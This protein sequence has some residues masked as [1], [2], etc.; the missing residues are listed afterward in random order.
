MNRILLIVILGAV[1]VAVALILQFTLIRE[2]DDETPAP[3]TSQQAA[4]QPAPA[5][6]AQPPAEA[7]ASETIKPSFDVVRVK[8]TGETVIAGRAQPGARVTITDNG[9]PLGEVVADERGEWVFLP[10]RPLTPGN[11][12]LSLSAQPPGGGEA[13]MS[14]NLVIAVVP[15][16]GTD[17]AGQTGTTSGVLAVIV[18]REGE[19]A[20]QVVQLPPTAGNLPDAAAP[21]QGALSLDTVDYDE[22]GNMI[23]GGRAEPGAEVRLYLDNEL[24]GRTQAGPD[25]RWEFRPTEPVA[26][27]LH[28][29]RADQIGPG[30]EVTARVETPFERAQP[31]ALAQ[32]GSSTAASVVVQPGNSLWRLARRSYGSGWQYTVIY[33]ANRGQ[34]RDPDL[35]YPGQVFVL[36]PTGGN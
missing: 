3:V 1:V 29:L 23:V 9:K 7:P 24:L 27:G 25:S 36:P 32:A 11:H 15:Q 19:G 31:G 16:P 35:I 33:D 17:I 34:I 5:T 2:G 10:D 22:R 14:D 26:P 30:G 21:R 4:T 12:E 8:P 18:P 6:I 20:T 13:V 28:S